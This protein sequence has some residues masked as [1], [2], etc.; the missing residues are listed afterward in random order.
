MP[1]IAWADFESEDYQGSGVGRKG[2]ALYTVGEIDEG[3]SL[4]KRIDRPSLDI[5][6]GK[7]AKKKRARKRKQVKK[8]RKKLKKQT[9]SGG[10]EINSG[11]L[12]LGAGLLFAF[13]IAG[14]SG[15]S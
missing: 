7:Q 3:V 12:Y 5:S 14:A 2:G 4:P 13:M 6:K 8:A 1:R 11:P 15:G 9:G 10:M